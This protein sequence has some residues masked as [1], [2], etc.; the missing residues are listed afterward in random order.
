MMAFP[1]ASAILVGG[2]SG[3]KTTML[4]VVVGTFLFQTTYLISGPI[5]NELLVPEV[6]EIF[7]MMI[8]N[9]V[10][11]YALLHEENRTRGGYA[12]Y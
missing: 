7:R 4:H 5:A 6:A 12:A 11:L 8:T 1:A 10:I 2:S 3:N 9:G